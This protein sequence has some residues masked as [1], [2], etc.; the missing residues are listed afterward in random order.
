MIELPTT[1]TTTTKTTTTTTSTTTAIKTT[2]QK[3]YS[4]PIFSRYTD[5]SVNNTS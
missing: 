2:S 1:K 5:I 3:P 4:I